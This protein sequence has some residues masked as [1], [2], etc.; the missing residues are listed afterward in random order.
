ME[1]ESALY[2]QEFPPEPFPEP[3]SFSMEGPCCSRA[4]GWQAFS[5]ERWG[6]RRQPQQVRQRPRPLFGPRR[7]SRLVLAGFAIIAALLGA[8]TL[9]LLGTAIGSALAESGPQPAVAQA[10]GNEDEP[11]S[12]PKADWRKGTVPSLFQR[13]AQ[14]ASLSYG[15][16][17]MGTHGCGPTCLS[18]AYIG[19]TGKTDK[20]PGAMALFSEKN[21]YIDAGIT[22]WALMG[23]GARQL[24][25]RSQELGASAEAVLGELA[26]G[27][28]VICSVGPGDF[29][30]E[31]HFI[32]LTAADTAGNVTVNDPNSIERSQRTWDIQGILG[33]CRNLWALSA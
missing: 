23:D 30:T 19:L 20:D 2:L 14:W 32:V 12:T 28:P 17:T 22:S 21:G 29:T 31:G 4:D 8:L 33:Q 15:D 1:N 18:M 27:H 24:G 26:A 6:G 25:L 11:A 3:R 13:D 10:A 7:R 16:G 9:W 5:R